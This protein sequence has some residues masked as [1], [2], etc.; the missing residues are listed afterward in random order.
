MTTRNEA[1]RALE[2]YKRE[3]AKIRLLEIEAERTKSSIYRIT[4]LVSGD[5]ATPGSENSREKLIFGYLVIKEQIGE[6]I[7]KAAALRATVEEIVSAIE[8]V[9][10]MRALVL[11]SRYMSFLSVRET[12]RELG[13]S[14]SR[15][16][17]LTRE[18]VESAALVI[19]IREA[20]RKENQ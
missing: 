3:S 16:K 17:Q 7:E 12:A 6:S 18:G 8:V 5:S 4:Q 19:S 15:V 1:Y 11:R 14:E 13:Y 9:N 2:S 20:Q 10:E